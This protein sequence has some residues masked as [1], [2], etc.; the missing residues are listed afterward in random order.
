MEIFLFWFILAIFIGVWAG[1]WGRSGFGYFLL[2]IILSPLIAGIILLISGTKDGGANKK[3]CP[4]CAEYVQEEAQVC[5]HCGYDFV[6]EFEE[7]TNEYDNE[8]D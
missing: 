4:K 2:S 6:E 3:K 5:K 1:N 7:D 8:S